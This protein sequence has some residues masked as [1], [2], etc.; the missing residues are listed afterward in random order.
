MA[1]AP[2]LQQESPHQGCHVTQDKDEKQVVSAQ[3]EDFPSHHTPNCQPKS[4]CP[5]GGAGIAKAR[6]R[7]GRGG[8]RAWKNLKVPGSSLEPAE[9]SGDLARS[10]E[11]SGVRAQLVEP[12]TLSTDYYTRTVQ[13]SQG[14][15]GTVQVQVTLTSYSR[16]TPNKR[17]WKKRKISHTLG[18]L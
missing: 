13:L 8:D 17:L 4:V 1:R 6:W 16:N 9:K 15:W 14:N 11:S 3:P 18:H 2:S 10:T 5:W 12:Q 7:L